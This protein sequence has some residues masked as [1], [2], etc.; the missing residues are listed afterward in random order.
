MKNAWEKVGNTTNPGK[1]IWDEYVNKETGESSLEIHTPKKI[2]NFDKCDHY[3]ELDKTGA[4]VVCRKCG[5]G[6]KFVWGIQ[7]LKDGKIVEK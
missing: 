1:P 6:H 7:F 3:Y 5:L 2:S 4:N